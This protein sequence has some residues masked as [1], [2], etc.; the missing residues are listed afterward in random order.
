MGFCLPGGERPVLDTEDFWRVVSGGQS[1]LEH[2]GF[3][4]G[5]VPLVPET[6]SERFP[7]VPEKHRR[8]YAPVHL[9][10]MI[11]MW[12]ACAD[13]GLVFR[14]GDLSRAA[15]LT[16]RA[17]TDSNFDSYLDWY[18]ADP[19][20]IEVERA[21][22]VIFRVMIA[23]TANDVGNVLAGLTRATGPVFSVTCG[24]ASSGVLLG[25]AH[26]MI[27]A[28]EIDTALVSGVDAFEISRLRHGKRLVDVA[29]RKGGEATFHSAP[30]VATRFDVPMRPYD[31][32]SSGM[33]LGDGAVTLVLESREHADRRGARGH[34]RILA[35]ATTRSGLP[36]AVSIDESGSCLVSAVRQC[37][38]TDHDLGE[39]PYING[40]AEGDPLFNVIESNA[41]CALYGS[42]ANDVLVTSQEACFG[43]DGAP[44]GAMGVASTLLMMSH[45]RIAPTANCRTPAEVCVFDP[46]P[47]N[48]P[49]TLA[50]SRALSFNY[51]LGGVSSVLFLGGPDDS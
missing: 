4:H 20:T 22:D 19:D 37:L 47:G 2:A 35:Q 12:Q 48:V 14:S 25:I 51:Q 29:S 42:A 7:E 45:G 10:G 40:G 26:R 50:F 44:L 6:F 30:P 32:D 8:H 34:G 9:L 21:K 18:R 39:I 36:S 17:G 31:E 15:V 38:G 23:G 33:N 16:A 46:V 28:G 11:S 3:H 1:H 13:A 43:H 41:V 49:R 27:A 24:C 5:I